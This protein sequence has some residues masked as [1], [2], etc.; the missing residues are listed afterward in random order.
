MTPA[1]PAPAPVQ[2]LTAAP[3][4]VTMQTLAAPAVETVEE[5]APLAL[6]LRRAQREDA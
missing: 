2:A 4:A 6:L 1:A 5:A 3:A